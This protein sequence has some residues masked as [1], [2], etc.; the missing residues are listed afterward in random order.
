M[1]S[2]FI[3]YHPVIQ[4]S[5]NY[6]STIDCA[7]LENLHICSNCMEDRVENIKELA[8]LAKLSTAT[9]SRI[10]NGKGRAYRISAAT[11]ERV[12]SLAARYHYSPNR[13]ARGLKLEKTETIGL[14]IPDIA[15]PFFASI[16]KTIELESR[17]K[18]YSIILCD[19]QDDIITEKE[20]LILLAGRKVAGIII[21]PAGTGCSHLCEFDRARIPVILVDRYF[22]DLE[23]P[24]VT[25]DNYQGAYHATRFLIES[26]HS[27]IAC[28]QGTPGISSSVERVKGF[29]DAL[30][31][32]GISTDSCFIVGNDFGE[33][34]GYTETMA[35][36]KQKDRP[37]AIFALGN[38]ISL[39][40]LR[41]ISDAGLQIPR[42]V[43]TVTFDDQ[44]YAAFL[45][46]PMTAVEQPRLEIARRAVEA[47]FEAIETGKPVD[48]EI[49]ITLMPELIVRDSVQ[50]MGVTIR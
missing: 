48:P 49:R 50:N 30:V 36:L 25:T 40:M 31:A 28:I 39:G 6:F 45:K 15:N 23:I 38:L 7:S 18:G 2:T 20:L 3:F 32:H 16:A 22:P 11:C 10:L 24:Y 47:L 33:L 12:L 17:K 46:T 34:N 14:I 43:S 41:A 26:G 19:S 27:R 35:L 42:D 37:S 1:I 8:A 5:E 21:A 9:V 13:I 44:P 4:M 29:T